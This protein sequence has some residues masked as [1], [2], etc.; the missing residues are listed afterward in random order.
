MN[1]LYV[2]TF[3]LLALLVCAACG[4]EE[5][6][7][8][9]HGTFTVERPFATAATVEVEGRW[10][11]SNAS[12]SQFEPAWEAVTRGSSSAE[13]IALTLSGGTAANAQ[14]MT[15]LTAFVV[16]LPTPLRA[17]QRYTIGT[18]IAPPSET[19]MPMYWHVWGPRAV[20]RAGE[21]DVALRVFDYQTIGMRVE[22]DFIAR[23]ATGTIEVLRR[24]EDLV[25]LRVD[26]TAHDAAGRMLRLHG[27]FEVRAERYTPPA[28]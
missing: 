18:A 19:D 20:T 15:V 21:A 25:E 12:S 5:K 27:D 1:R 7:L 6:S 16:V 17:G 10:F 22:N 24:G 4:E 13:A 9:T 14:G 8:V 3:A 23:V 11:D 28:T 26:V 2:R